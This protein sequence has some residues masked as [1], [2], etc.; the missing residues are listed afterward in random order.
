MGRLNFFKSRVAD[1][2]SIFFKDNL[3]PLSLPSLYALSSVFEKLN[4]YLVGYLE[5]VVFAP[6]DLKVQGNRGVTH[7]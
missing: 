5:F 4:Y 2:L 3:F 7:E 6:P 1:P